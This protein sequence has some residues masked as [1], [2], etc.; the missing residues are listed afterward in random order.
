LAQVYKQIT[1][2]V[3]QLGVSSL[4]YA[5]SSIT[6]NDTT[7]NNYLTTIAN[8]TSTRNN[9]AAQMMSLLNGAAFSRQPIQPKQANDLISQGNQ[10][11]STVQGLA[12]Q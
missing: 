9:L 8:I 12:G 4:T 2:P 1:A 11:I 10:L 6:S 3:G 7:Y 5:N